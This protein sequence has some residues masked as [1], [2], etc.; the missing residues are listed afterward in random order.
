MF[1]AFLKFFQRHCE[2]NESIQQLFQFWKQVFH[3]SLHDSTLEAPAGMQTTDIEDHTK[4]TPSSCSLN[5]S[6]SM[7]TNSPLTWATLLIFMPGFNLNVNKHPSI[8]NS[9]LEVKF[10][11]KGKGRQTFKGVSLAHLIS[12]IR[13]SQVTKHAPVTMAGWTY[14][15]YTGFK[16]L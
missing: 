5:S 15:T 3:S 9:D 7:T 4:N 16:Y 1:P 14:K 10:L 6:N 2:T 12:A 8:L 13:C 11:H